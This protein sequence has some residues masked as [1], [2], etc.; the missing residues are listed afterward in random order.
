MAI[1]GNPLQKHFR[2][3]QLYLKLPSRGRW[4]AQGAVNI[5]PTGELAVFSMTARDELA[6]KTPDALLNG[7]STVDVIQSCLPDIRDP[8]EIPV[9]DLDAILISIRQATYGNKM[10]YVSICPHCQHK[11]EHVADLGQIMGLIACPDFAQTLKVNGLEFYFKPETYRTFNKNSIKNF[12]EQRLIQSVTNDALSDEEKENQFTIIF[13]KLLDMTVSKLADNV[14]AIKTPDSTITNSE[15]ILDFFHNCDKSVWNQVKSH[16][17]SLGSSNPIKE[18]D[19]TCDNDE[20]KKSYKT[21]LVFELS[22][23]FG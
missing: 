8:W 13:K 21:P 23:F 4:W 19:V 3:P 14:A 2:Q 12:E 5:P 9:V 15:Y 20:C 10:D 22:N 6:I 17:E 1:P 16:L 7:Q 11:N 18:L